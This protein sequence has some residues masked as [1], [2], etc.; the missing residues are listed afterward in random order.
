MATLTEQPKAIEAPSYDQDFYLWSLRTA[1]LI[2]AGRFEQVDR[3]NV[4]E[5][6]ESLAR[7]D[8]AELK[9]RTRTLIAH[10]LKRDFQPQKHT[11]SWDAT[12]REQRVTIQDNIGDIPSLRRRLPA[13]IHDLYEDAVA[14]AMD[15]TALERN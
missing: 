12:I 4:A 15:E 5:E 3:E 13:L 6:I 11:R 2:R 9:S 1:E 7:R 8:F 10:L 14:R